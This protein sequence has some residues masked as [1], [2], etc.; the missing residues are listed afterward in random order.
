VSERWRLRIY[1]SRLRIYSSPLRNF[2]ERDT[3]IVHAAQIISNMEYARTPCGISR[4]AGAIH[5]APRDLPVTCLRCLAAM[6]AK[7]DTWTHS[8]N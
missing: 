2:M 1:S 7:G 6:F 8:P 3:T 4:G 5:E